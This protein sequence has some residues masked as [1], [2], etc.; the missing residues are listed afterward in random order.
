[1]ALDGAFLSKIKAELQQEIGAHLDKIYQPSKD[2]LVFLLRSKNGTNRLLL[3]ATPGRNRVHFTKTRPENP[4]TAPMF[5][6]LLRK[7]LGAARLTEVRQNGLERV[8]TLVFSSTN[9]MG[10]VIYPSMVC[11]MITASPNLILC[12]E[13]NRILGAVRYSDMETGGRLIQPGALYSP[14]APQHKLSL[15]D[16]ATA[17]LA[18]SILEKT[19]LSLSKALLQTAD[20]LSPLIC[21]EIAVLICRDPDKP[22]NELTMAERMNLTGQL[23][24][25]CGYLFQTDSPVLLCDEQDEPT[26]FCFM[27]ITQYGTAR[28]C[29]AC[30]SFSDALDRYYA[31]R[32]TSARIRKEAGDMLKLLAVLC[33]RTTKKMAMRKTELENSRNREHFRIYGELLK[34]NLYAVPKGATD[35]SVINYY[36]PDQKPIRIPLLPALSAAANADRYFKEYKK[37]YAAEKRLTELLAEDEKD[38]AYYDSVLDSLSRATSLTDLSEIKEEMYHTGLLKRTGPKTSRKQPKPSFLRFTSPTGYTVLVG[39]N[40]QQNDLL[41]LSTAE[42]TDW[43]F[44]AK[45]CPGS[46]TVILCRKTTPD[47]ETVLMAASLAAY[48]SKARESTRVAVDYT[49]IRYIKKPSGA[50]PGM[51][52]YTTN[53]TVTVV[54]DPC[55]A[56]SSNEK[57]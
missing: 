48:H 15:T 30:D 32:E 49:P 7:Y 38:L 6:M 54:P 27:P 20:G 11:E 53:R 47:D 18:S 35:V 29:L 19:A 10:D 46:H 33:S 57:T 45:G 12:D 26:D 50:K 56:F 39:R 36:D 21:R 8:L 42:K 16:T 43:W 31:Q 9:E 23:N 5:C 4:L 1:M 44:H 40:N 51:V 13:D 37:S 17:D 52:I 24:R 28:K 3:C 2:E 41:T 55:L 22:V 25:L 14:P 34:A